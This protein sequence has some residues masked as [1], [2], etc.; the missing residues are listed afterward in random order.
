MQKKKTKQNIQIIRTPKFKWVN[1]KT[2]TKKDIDK[3]SKSFKIEKED[4]EECLPPL[5]RSKIVERQDYT[6][7]I[8][9]FPIFNNKENKVDFTELGIFLRKKTIITTQSNKHH[10][11]NNFYETC[12]KEKNGLSMGKIISSIIKRM[13]DPM[14]PML[15]DIATNLDELEH[16]VLKFNDKKVI[17]QILTARTDLIDFKK[18]IQNHRFIIQRLQDKTNVGIDKQTFMRFEHVK[19]NIQIIWD[20]LENEVQTI[21]TLH[22]S[23]ESFVGFHTNAVVKRLTILSAIVLPL[24]LLAG[25][26]G[27]NVSHAP[28]LGHQFDFWI[29]I[30]IMLAG[31]LISYLFFRLVKW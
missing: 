2:L 27:M 14:F 16:D 13:I 25:I 7:I 3:I 30:G 1:I 8:M 15:D 4:L 9:V 28:I 29:L 10:E 24:V 12:L 22:E 6:F 18:A 26:F 11:I 23:H 21:K 5:Q 31:S 17:K 20:L 19:D